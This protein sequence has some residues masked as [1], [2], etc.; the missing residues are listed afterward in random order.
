L[1]DGGWSVGVEYYLAL[2]ARINLLLRLS[3]LAFCNEIT[4]HTDAGIHPINVICK[5]RH[6]IPVSILPLRINDKNGKNIAIKVISLF[7]YKW[8]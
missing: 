8:L 2:I 6:I 3:A 4:A 7:S 1:A 5:I